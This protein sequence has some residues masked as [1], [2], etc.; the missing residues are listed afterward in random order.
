[1]QLEIDSWCT[2]ILNKRGAD[3]VRVCMDILEAGLKK[4]RVT[5][6]DVRDVTFDQPNI[7]GGI[8]K[9]CMLKCGFRKL[10]PHRDPE[11]WSEKAVASKKNGREL[12][13][14]ILADHHKALKAMRQ[15]KKDLLGTV[16]VTNNHYELAL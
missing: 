15:F 13:I 4:G 7:I 8:F 9:G 11:P 3:G 5:A 12:Q 2:G 14:W 16:A 6:N 10:D 1:M